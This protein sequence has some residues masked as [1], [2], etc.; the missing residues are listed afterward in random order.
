MSNAAMRPIRYI[1]FHTPGPRWQPGV[2]FREQ[3][4]VREHIQH[5]LK[6]HEQGNWNLAV[7]FCYRMQAA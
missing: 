7:H 2:D 4:G 6:F 5:Y 1:V 3:D